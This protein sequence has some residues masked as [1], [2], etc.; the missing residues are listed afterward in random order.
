MEEKL[1]KRISARK[2]EKGDFHH[3]V[4]LDR[5]G[6]GDAHREER[7]SSESLASESGRY[8]RRPLPEAG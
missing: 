7:K 5:V 4:H 8:E 6:A 2:N 1:E 3:A